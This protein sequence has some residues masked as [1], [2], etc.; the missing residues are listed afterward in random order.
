MGK[1]VLKRVILSFFTLFIIMSLTF[2]LIKLLPFER[3]VGGDD[4]QVPYYDR[5]FNLGYV[6]RLDSPTDKYGELLYKSPT[7]K[8]KTNYY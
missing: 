7:V 3:P 5:Q 4:V 2:I 8:G 6:Y 1:Y